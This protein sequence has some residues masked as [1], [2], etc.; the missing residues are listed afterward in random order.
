MLVRELSG[1]SE[2]LKEVNFIGAQSE[3]QFCADMGAVQRASA[4]SVNL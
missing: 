2:I 1:K 3:L 4:A